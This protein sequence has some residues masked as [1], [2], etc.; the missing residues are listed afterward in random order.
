MCVWVVW[1]DPAS[2][3]LM[4]GGEWRKLSLVGGR[5]KKKR[6]RESRGV[7]VSVGVAHNRLSDLNRSG[8]GDMG[9]MGK[10]LGGCGW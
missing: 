10:I 6:E 5:V 4:W 2:V 9:N 8:G 7:Q 3:L 1:D